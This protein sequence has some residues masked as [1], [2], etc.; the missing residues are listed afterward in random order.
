MHA[1]LPAIKQ[2]NYEILVTLAY[3]ITSLNCQ[4]I[5]LP[6][7][8][9]MMFVFIIWIILC[10]LVDLFEFQHSFYYYI[11]NECKLNKIFLMMQR[12]VEKLI[13]TNY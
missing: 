12:L 6:I 8:K 1:K 11:S 13:F 5:V 9:S 7:L 4:N 3:F 2:K 10:I